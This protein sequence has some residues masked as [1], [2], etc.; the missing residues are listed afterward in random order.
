MVGVGHPLRGDD[1]IGSFILRELK[2]S[3]NMMPVNVQLVNAEDS[4][5]SV[6]TKLV[7]LKPKHVIFIDACEMNMKPGE[8]RL[9][10]VA[11][12]E[13]PFFTTHGIPLKLLSEQLLPESESWIL[14][15]QPKQVQFSDNPSPE[16]HRVALEIS[17]YV[18][19]LLTEVTN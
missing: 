1:Y 5:E 16:V 6:I 3:T 18:S 13:Y 11:A 4:V 2:R 10:P 12:T 8:I 15:V 14:A 9:I 17:E 7:E 19:K